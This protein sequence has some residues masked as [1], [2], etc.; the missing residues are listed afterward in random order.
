MYLTLLQNIVDYTTVGAANQ[1]AD[2]RRV[3]AEADFAVVEPA[4]CKR[5]VLSI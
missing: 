5:F 2:R 3:A 4:V 1:Q